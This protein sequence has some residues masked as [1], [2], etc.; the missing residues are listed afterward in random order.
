MDGMIHPS[1]CSAH[2]ADRQHLLH[3]SITSCVAVAWLCHVWSDCVIVYKAFPCIRLQGAESRGDWYRTKD[4]ILKVNSIF[5]FQPGILS[6]L[7]SAVMPAFCC[8]SDAAV[9]R[10][11]YA[12]GQWCH[13]GVCA[14]S[15]DFVLFLFLLLAVC[16][17]VSELL[18]SKF[19]FYCILLP[20]G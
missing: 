1:R 10:C 16:C 13:N 2:M 7:L 11:L 6:G 8:E 5:M 9:I 19:T 14:A 17:F 4:L 20:T 3:D 12:K 18:L 15:R